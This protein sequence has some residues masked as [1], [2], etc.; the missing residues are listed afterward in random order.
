MFHSWKRWFGLF[1]ATVAALVLVAVFWTRQ[2]VHESVLESARHQMEEQVRI[3][4]HLLEVGD[5][6]LDEKVDRAAQDTSYRIT[7]ID[8]SGRVVAD[9]AFSGQALQRMENH[10]NREEFREARE[11]GEGVAHR[12]STSIDG[13]LLYSATGTADGRGFVRLAIPIAAQSFAGMNLWVPLI[14]GFLMLAAGFLVFLSVGRRIG[15]QVEDLSQGW[16]KIREADFSHRIPLHSGLELGR[17]ARE[18]DETAD[19]LQKRFAG[20]EAERDHFRTILRS[21]SEGVLVADGKGRIAKVNP[22]FMSMF[23]VEKD[24]VGKRP[25][26][27]VRNSEIQTGIHQVLASGGNHE[28]EILVGDK[29]LLA[30]FAPIGEAKQRSGVVTVFHDITRLRRL[31]NLRKE[32]VSNVSHELKTPLTSI[33]GFAETLLEE[34]WSNP[35]HRDFLERIERNCQ[36]LN[37]IIDDLFK[38]ASLEGEDRRLKYR[39]IAFTDLVGDLQKEFQARLK[40]NSINFSTANRSGH[41]SFAAEPGYIKR[42]FHNLMD[43][44]LKYTECGEIRVELDSSPGYLVFSV[45][46]TGSGIPS[47]DLSRIFERFYRVHKDR[48][49]RTGGS[50]IGLSIVKHIV[51]LH[52]GRV[53]AESEVGRGT[54]VYFTLPILDQVAEADQHG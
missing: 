37:Q 8:L 11:Q 50:G 15:R 46:D 51:Q 14:A 22:A 32:F 12:Y 48:S 6:A 45:H 33:K 19:R 23:R 31:E 42:V 54:V 10:G 25:L 29:V 13:W 26:E 28:E 9:S 53:W 20:L 36:Q 27:V 43:N 2:E 21:M 7:V 52:G 5:P 38:L 1:L 39:R 34:H 18:T 47:G 30:R 17:L 44:A 24:P 49:R 3:L 40:E 41:D 35:L 16:S 4:A